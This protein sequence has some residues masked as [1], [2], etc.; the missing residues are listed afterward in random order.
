MSDPAPRPLL[1]KEVVCHKAS[2]S[3]FRVGMDR[4][5]QN[6]AP[7]DLFLPPASLLSSV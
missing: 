5:S 2:K 7:V 1:T 4:F 3:R 6:F